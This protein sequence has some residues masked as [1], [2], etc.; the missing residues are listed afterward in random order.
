MG[1]L[2]SLKLGNLGAIRTATS[3]GSKMKL[4][5]TFFV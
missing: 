1:K 3:T 2:L 4:F 5:A